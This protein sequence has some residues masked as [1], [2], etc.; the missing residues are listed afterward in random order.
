MD[1]HPSTFGYLNPTENQKDDMERCRGAAATYA[2]TIE[3]VVPDGPD[4]TYIIRKLREVA[5]WVNVSIT[6]GPDGTPRSD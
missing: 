6:R 5:M 4:K 1:L 2:K 3:Q